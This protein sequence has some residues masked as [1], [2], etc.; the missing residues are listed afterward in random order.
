MVVS[1]GAASERYTMGWPRLPRLGRRRL[2]A[3]ASAS[4]RWGVGVS[5]LGRRRLSV[6]ASASH[7]WGVGVSLLGRRR[8]ESTGARKE[9]GVVW[10]TWLLTEVQF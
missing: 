9:A 1:S 4:Q 6:G 7:R 10:T 8:L 2:S 5:A 3:G